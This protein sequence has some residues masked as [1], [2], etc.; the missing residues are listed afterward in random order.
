[1]FRSIGP[2]RLYEFGFQFPVKAKDFL[3]SIGAS[4]AL[5]IQRAIS[6]GI[7]WLGVKLTTHLHLL[8]RLRIFGAIPPSP[9]VFIAWCLIKYRDAFT[10]PFDTSRYKNTCMF[11]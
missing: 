6:S 9:I 4:S 1:L 2:S 5:G 7:K 10:L 11:K 3:F 8:P